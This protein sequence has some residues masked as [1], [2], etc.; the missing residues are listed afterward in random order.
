MVEA[1]VIGT[2]DVVLDRRATWHLCFL[3][4]T[5]RSATFTF[6]DEHSVDGSR[7]WMRPVRVYKEFHSPAARRALQKLNERLTELIAPHQRS[8]VF[9]RSL[10]MELCKEVHDQLTVMDV[11]QS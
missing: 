4:V 3:K 2:D 7:E 10:G 5:R 1:N 9:S 8:E 6:T 11:L